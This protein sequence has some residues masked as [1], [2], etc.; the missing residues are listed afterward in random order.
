M[1]LKDPFSLKTAEMTK[2]S[3]KPRKL[4]E[5]ESSDEISGLTCQHVSKA[6]E[7]NSVKKAVTGSLWSV[8]CDCMRERDVFESEQAGAHD[9]LVCLKCGFQGCSQS[10]RQHSV[11]HQQAHVSDSHCISIS[12]STWKAWCFE[13]NEELSTHC[14][15]KA[16]AQT[17]DFL[18]KH[19]AKSASGSTSKIIKLIEEPVEYSEPARGKSPVNSTLIPVKGI[20]NLGNTCFF[21]AVMQNLS[22]T[23][24]LN[25]LIQEVKEK[26]HKMKICLPPE[27]N[28]GPLTV[29]LAG[30]E[31]LT[32]AMMLFLYSMKETGKGPVSP[33]ILFT[34]LCQKAPRFKGY[35]QQDSQELLHYLLD[36][37]RMEENKD[38]RM[39]S[40]AVT[41][42]ISD[43][44]ICLKRIKAAIL[45]AFNNPTEKTADEETKRQVK[46]YGKEGVK[47]NFVDRIFVGELTNT[48]MCEEC[49][50][51]STV[52]EAFIDISLPIIEERISKPSN[53]GRLSKPGR[54]Q[55]SPSAHADELSHS[56]TTRNGK[57]PS[58]Q[59]LQ[60]RRSS[61]CH[62]TRGTDE[63]AFTLREDA[64]CS[65][66]HCCPGDTAGSQS[67][68]SEKDSSPQDSSNDADSEASESESSLQV[69][70][71]SNK[72]LSSSSC[73]KPTLSAPSPA[74]IVRE[75][76]GSAVE[77]LVSAVSKL[78][79]VHTPLDGF[80]LKEKEARDR[81]REQQGAF[82]ALSHSYTPA[83]KECSVQSC[84]HQF[85][86]IEL[87]MG[88]NKL[89]CENCTERRHRQH[90]RSADKKME[91]V[92]TS[93]RKQMLI[94]ELPPVVTLHLKRFHQAGMNFR[95]VNRHVDF[96]LVL[97]LAP[98]CSASCKN[99]GSGERVLYSLYGIVE[100]SGSMRGGHYTAYV[101]VRTPQRKCEQHRSQSGCREAV[102]A[103]PGQWVYVSD[104]SVQTVSESRVLNSQ[105]YLLFYEEIL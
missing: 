79:L 12:L 82:Q 22:Q 19:S 17:L 35:Q 33:K 59:K 8:C 7:L 56:H 52:K 11:K 51:I 34:Q 26:G 32:S 10:E 58:I 36:S 86:S 53:P 18:Q 76:T 55:E 41:C 91:K 70:S 31:P 61:T 104:T 44:L 40:F 100:H 74:P 93:A 2:R 42:R 103:P 47:M 69:S 16:L 48:I 67:D 96:P 71:S 14:N 46:A 45:K 1:R 43:K 13:C 9:I 27:T 83:S 75:Q 78:G 105:A 73:L 94:S 66:G 28:L 87:L 6:V 97:D 89:L 92:Y 5:E 95:K 90:K 102:S 84:L 25:D 3:N 63:S 49:E 101:K 23:H 88:N 72:G 80:P 4:R 38:Q 24:M 54:D 77:Q 68:A 98:F 50:H 37:V 15:K 20:I 81:E 62:D 85:T 64:T 65:R 57:K 39:H 30:P 99:L 21:N 60:G 29:T